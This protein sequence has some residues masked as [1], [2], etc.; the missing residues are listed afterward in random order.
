VRAADSQTFL[1]SF[2]FQ[3]R[4][5]LEDG[6]PQCAIAAAA[7]AADDDDDATPHTPHSSSVCAAGLAFEIN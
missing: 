7:A 3:S 2:E 6:L 5:S 4:I 1:F